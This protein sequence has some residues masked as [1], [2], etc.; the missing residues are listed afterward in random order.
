VGFV[1]DR[2]ALGV[3]RFLLTIILP[4][5]PHISSSIIRG[6]YNRPVVAD[7][8]QPHHKKLKRTLNSDT[9]DKLGMLGYFFITLIHKSIHPFI[10]VKLL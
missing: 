6:W 2:V 8:L 3:L 1:V 9:L 7:V 5:D 10:I 4:T